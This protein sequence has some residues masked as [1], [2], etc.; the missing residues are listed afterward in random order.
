MGIIKFIKNLLNIEQH[1]DGELRISEYADGSYSVERWET[2]NEYGGAYHWAT[3]WYN[4]TETTG[5]Y[6]RG[7][8][9]EEARRIRDVLDKQRKAKIF[10]KVID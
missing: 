10:V 7:L 3:A 9:L 8:T 4:Q 6:A 1:E 2:E 5:M